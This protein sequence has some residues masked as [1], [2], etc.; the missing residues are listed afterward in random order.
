MARLVYVE[1]VPIIHVKCHD[2]ADDTG[3]AIN[4]LHRRVRDVEL[5]AQLG[6]A[7]ADHTRDVRLVPGDGDDESRLIPR[8]RDDDG[9]ARCRRRKGQGPT[10]VTS[11]PARRGRA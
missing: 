9:G 5:E 11:R 10:L 4:R 8:G 3:P 6:I 1:R 7:E 2:I